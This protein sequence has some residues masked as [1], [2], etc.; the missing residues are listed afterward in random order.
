MFIGCGWLWLV[1]VSCGKFGCFG[2]FWLVCIIVDWL[3]LLVLVG[4]GWLWFVLAGVGW[5]WLV[6]VGLV[7]WFRLV[8]VCWFGY[9]MACQ[10][11]QS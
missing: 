8:V 9:V 11:N 7:G 2:W 5:L 6:L 4:C 10:N 3:L 1:L